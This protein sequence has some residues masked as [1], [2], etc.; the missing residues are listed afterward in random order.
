MPTAGDDPKARDA[1]GGGEGEFRVADQRR[2][3][4]RTGERRGSGESVSL[5]GGGVMNAPPAAPDVKLPVNFGDLVQPFLLVGLAGLGVLPQPDTNQA[6]IDLNSAAAAIESL[7]L[8]K[9]K[10]EGNRTPAETRLLE[11]ALYELKMQFVDARERPR[12]G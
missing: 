11:Q 10:T 4:P 3:D 6:E 8:L 2:F 9:Q 1:A 7:E 12:R 5:P